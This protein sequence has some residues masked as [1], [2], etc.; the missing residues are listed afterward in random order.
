MREREIVMVPGPRIVG[1]LLETG[2]PEFYNQFIMRM[3]RDEGIQV[4]DPAP[5]LRRSD[6]PIYPPKG[7]H[8][9]PHAN[10]IFAR[11]VVDAMRNP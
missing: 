8:L 5:S 9:S 1:T 3:I 6:E 2:Y 10:A 11:A 4:I 7:G